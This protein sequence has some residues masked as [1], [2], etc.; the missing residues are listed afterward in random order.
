VL[1]ALAERFLYHIV[2]IPYNL[3]REVNEE[4]GR[5]Q[6]LWPFYQ[7]ML[8][9]R[10]L[11]D[12]VRVLTLHMYERGVDVTIPSARVFPGGAGFTSEIEVEIREA[13]LGGAPLLQ[14]MTGLTELCLRIITREDEEESSPLIR[15]CME[16]LFPGF[17]H[18]IAH[19]Q[20]FPGLRNLK[21]LH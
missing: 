17:D 16:K 4:I 20:Y 18:R 10:D 13:Q 1:R 15:D 11:A 2:E 21:F 6:E 19:K 3:D 14:H 12:R 9:R 7:T 5:G 8:R